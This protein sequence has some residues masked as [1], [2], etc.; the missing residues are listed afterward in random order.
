MPYRHWAMNFTFTISFN[1]QIYD[2]K[3]VRYYPH[4]IDGD[5]RCLDSCTLRRPFS[6]FPCFF[7]Y[8]CKSSNFT[9][10]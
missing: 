10:S 6:L 2:M 7:N 3:W 8:P 9:N 4:F 1:T 5:N